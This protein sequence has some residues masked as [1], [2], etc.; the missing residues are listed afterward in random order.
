MRKGNAVVTE[1]LTILDCP[2]DASTW[3]AIGGYCHRL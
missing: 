3:N 2:F 1:L